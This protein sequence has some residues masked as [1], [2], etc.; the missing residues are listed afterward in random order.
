MNQRNQRRAFLATAVASAFAGAAA[1]T[2]AAPKERV[3]SMVAK[4]WEFVPATIHAARGETL[5]F[6]ITAPEVPM[7]FNLPDFDSRI[8]VLPG[9]V[10]TLKVTPDRPGTFTFLCD[11]FCGD[12]HETM[13][14]QLVVSG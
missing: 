9:K 13:N 8:D 14:G 2:I 12:G 4:K 5:V 11:V 7:G 10:A 3:V 6:R 1:F